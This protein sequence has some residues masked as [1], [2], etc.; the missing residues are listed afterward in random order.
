MMKYI[1]KLKNYGKKTISK[2]DLETLFAVS[3]D[4]A[5]FGIISVL[6][7]KQI[8]S[9][10]KSSKTNGN[11]LY[12]IYLKYKVLLPQDTYETELKE[13]SSLHPL[14][15]NN[16]LLEK[17]SA[18][19]TTLPILR[20]QLA[21]IEKGIYNLINAIQAGIITQS[22]KQRLD[23]LEAQKSEISVAGFRM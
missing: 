19:S 22:T 5:L 15:Q 14:L 21:E 16:K 12:P 18:E 6:Y 7:E 20:K 13:I 4:E 11:R 23:E 8:L 2:T 1:E 3:S 10:I 17:L 9:P